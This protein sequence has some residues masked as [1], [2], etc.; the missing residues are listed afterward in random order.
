MPTAFKELVSSEQLTKLCENFSSLFGAATAIVDL[1]GEVLFP[2]GWKKACVAFHRKNPITVARCTE[3]DTQLATQMMEGKGYAVYHCKNGLIDVAVP[4]VVNSKHVANLF[5]GQ[6][7]FEKADPNVFAP[8]AAEVG[9]DKEEYLKAIG[10]IPVFSQERVKAMITFLRQIA[11][12]I[13]ELG[14]KNQLL[15]ATNAELDAKQLSLQEALYKASDSEALLRTILN[16]IDAS[17]Y[18]KDASGEYLYI[19]KE[20]SKLL[21]PGAKDHSHPAM[22]ELCSDEVLT[23]LNATDDQVFKGKELSGQEIELASRTYLVTKVP[24]KHPDGSIYAICGV[25]VDITSIKHSEKEI[26]RSHKLLD[27]VINNI[28]V[29]VLL[30]STKGNN[31]QLINTPTEE[32]LGL[33][34]DKLDSE[35][36]HIHCD[37]L[38]L[39]AIK[40]DPEQYHQD[41]P[42]WS[43]HE[44]VLED[45]EK[46]FYSKRIPIEDDEGSSEFTLYVSE[47]ISE[48]KRTEERIKYQA[49]FD[50]LTGLPNRR[51]LE[52]NLAK[53]I[54][55]AR[56][57]KHQLAYLFIDLD[58]FKDINDTSGHDVGDQ[59]IIETARRIK[60]CIRDKD[61][62]ARYGGDEVIVVI[63]CHPNLRVAE[64]IADQIT[65]AL[66][67]PFNISHEKFF[68]TASIGISIYPDHA[69]SPLELL[70]CADQA[71]YHA[72]SNNRGGFSYFDSS[73]QVQVQNRISLAKDMHDALSQNQFELYY[74][75]IVDLKKNQVY[76]AEALLRWKHP[77]HGF[78][79]P[80][81]F[82]PI[83]E[84]TGLIHEIGDWVFQTALKN[85]K[86]LSNELGFPFQISVNKSPVQ[87]RQKGADAVWLK[88]LKQD[89]MTG[90]NLC[91]EI[92][93]GV[94][95]QKDDQV[96][97]SLNLYRDL[98]IEVSLDDFATGYSS[99]SYLNRFDIDYLKIDKSFIDNL[100]P[101]T[102]NYA[103]CEA[104]VVM[105]EKLGVKVVAEGVE[106]KEQLQYISQIGCGYV[107]GYVFSKPLPGNQFRMFVSEFG[108]NTQ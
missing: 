42:E 37:P 73:M 95:L 81:V 7:L 72:K 52:E 51:Q 35:N 16:N 71:M 50:Q 83:A 21:C 98:G 88:Q 48:R 69:R 32:F 84:A 105:A 79:S 61:L 66:S 57:N 85:S 24:V 33:P 41:M 36:Y 26:I 63:E 67:K 99:L 14:Y 106:T 76:K 80:E 94:L 43:E 100:H 46:V 59:V 5:A 77:Q 103:L 65:L 74:Q 28:P 60:S 6:F 54:S 53:T 38:R 9:F 102:P 27:T 49:F 86:K 91:I 34:K 19:N 31:C 12:T 90:E 22:T 25:L 15:I 97:D 40:G 64:K 108:N 78:I 23:P 44:V 62:I 92:T 1:N 13:G 87:Y 89:G 45:E 4:I 58:H 18:L 75:P 55:Q 101:A 107:Q 29:M 8:Q 10:D 2:S 70:K 20:L 68:L 30:E 56:E 39:R 11:E 104:I 93:E 82:I 47:D 3:S 96:I 17:I